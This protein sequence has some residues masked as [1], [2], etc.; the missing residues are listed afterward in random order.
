MEQLELQFI[1]PRIDKIRELMSNV[2]V[3]RREAFRAYNEARL[4]TDLRLKEHLI[5]KAKQIIEEFKL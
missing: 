2:N 1:T 5:N 4:T 3:K